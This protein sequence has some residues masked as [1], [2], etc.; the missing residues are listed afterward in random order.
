VRRGSFACARTVHLL[1][2]PDSSNGCCSVF[3][4]VG[5]FPFR[6]PFLAVSPSPPHSW[7]TSRTGTLNS[8]SCSPPALPLPGAAPNQDS[9]T[10]LLLS[11]FAPAALTCSAEAFPPGDDWRLDFPFAPPSP[12]Q[13]RRM[14][15]VRRRSQ[16]N[17]LPPVSSTAVVGPFPVGRRPL[18]LRFFSPPLFLTPNALFS[19]PFVQL[20]LSE[21]AAVLSPSPH[22]VP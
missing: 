11:W 5:A 22:P 7:R 15:P 20:P 6:P 1:G 19:R 8:Q 17:F 2:R 9:L 21:L 13:A 4:C 3:T 14:G 18:A 12:C 10:G 16:L